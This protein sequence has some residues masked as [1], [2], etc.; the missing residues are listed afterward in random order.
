ME[1][2]RVGAPYQNAQTL[3]S[4]A[5][6][7]RDI[8]CFTG[9][10]AG[11]AAITGAIVS[12]VLFGSAYERIKELN[13]VGKLL[14]TTFKYDEATRSLFKIIS[15][16]FLTGGAMLGAT[17]GGVTMGLFYRAR[18]L[19]NQAGEAEKRAESEVQING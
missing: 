14:K 3:R 12:I 9:A 19:E 11:T 5:S 16:G 8:A 1:D 18:S 4:T 2:N 15:L 6:T 7:Y 13:E 17:V 10:V